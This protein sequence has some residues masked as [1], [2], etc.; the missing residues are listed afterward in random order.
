M[1]STV[2]LIPEVF[3]GSRSPDA[4][5]AL[6]SGDE[7]ASKLFVADALSNPQHVKFAL[8]G[9]LAATLCYIV[10][11]SLGEPEISTAV[12]TCVLTALTT[13]GASRQKQVL[14]LS[15]ALAGGIVGIAALVFIL[16]YLDSIGGFTVLFLAVTIPAAWISTSS[17]RL[18]YFGVQLALAFY[19]MNLQE[20]KVQTS[21]AVARDRILGILLGLL[22]MWLVFDQLWGA[23]AASAMK[24]AFISVLRLLAQ[25]ERE[26]RSTDIP[27]AIE[28]GD[29]LRETINEAFDNVRAVADGVLFEFGPTRQ[30]DLALSDKIRQWQPQLRLLFLTRIVLLRYRLQLPGFELPEPVR[31]AQL[32]FDDRLAAT[33]DGMADRM[34]GKGPEVRE[35]LEDSLERLEQTTLT[36]CPELP[37]EALATPLQTFLPLCRRI[38]SLTSALDKEI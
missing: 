29:S 13:I 20:F 37:K 4:Y 21:L 19:L 3:T 27:A 14:R 32:E 2:S 16:P 31:L 17:P 28:R 25:L 35:N 5:E 12:V 7:P 38:E 6:P 18:S 24:K 11:T 1:E 26:P 33:L 23:S 9:C 34:E 10:Y 22:V 8:K 15:G 30:Q 36:C